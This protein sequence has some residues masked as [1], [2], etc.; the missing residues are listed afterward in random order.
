MLGKS[1]CKFICKLQDLTTFSSYFEAETV[2]WSDD[3]KAFLLVSE[4]HDVK[5]LRLSVEIFPQN[6]GRGDGNGSRIEVGRFRDITDFT[7]GADNGADL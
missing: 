5:K 3:E 4:V 7:R 2:S 6:L 1:G